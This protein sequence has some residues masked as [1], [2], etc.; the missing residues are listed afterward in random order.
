M[1]QQGNWIQGM[2]DGI[3]PNMNLGVLPMPINDDKEAMDKLP[4]GVPNNW[5]VNKNSK[6]KEEAKKF[7]EWMVTSDTGKKYIVEKFKFI[8]A[9]KTIEGKNLGPIAD[10]LLKYSAEG[11]TLSWNWFKYPDGATNEFG[12]SMQAY[13]GKQKSANEMLKS[14]EDSWMKLKK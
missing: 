2:V 14:L 4:M 6:N 8:P 5:V 11:K 7:L 13:V 9:L 3:T 10:D 12:A 1:I